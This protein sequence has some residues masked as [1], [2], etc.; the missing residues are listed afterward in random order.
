MKRIP[1]GIALLIVFSMF[2]IM[3]GC[4]S[5]SPTEGNPGEI[6]D[7]LTRS[8]FVDFNDPYGGFNMMDTPPAF[9]DPNIAAEYDEDAT[10]DDPIL[11]DTNVRDIATNDTRPLFLLITWGNLN[12]DSTIVN[13]TDWSGSLSIDPGVLVLKRTIR[14]EDRDRILRREQRELIEWVSYT[15]LRFDG[16]LVRV[17][18]TLAAADCHLEFE[19]GM[20]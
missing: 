12:R 5:D 13:G 4:S 11:D 17:I 1:M 6:E 14:F 2:A 19:E 15:Q 18:V 9:G 8:E 10:F 3:A 20:G 7:L 16:I